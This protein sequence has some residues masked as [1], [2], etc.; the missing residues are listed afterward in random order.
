MYKNSIRDVFI[1]KCIRNQNS[2]VQGITYLIR[3]WLC[4]VTTMKSRG[5]KRENKGMFATTGRSVKRIQGP[6]YEHEISVELETTRTHQLPKKLK[7]TKRKTI[8]ENKETI[9]TKAI[10]IVYKILSKIA[11]QS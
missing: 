5:V 1:R 7:H 4:G 2:C 9:Q 11:I 3:P 8:Q 10:K 6:N